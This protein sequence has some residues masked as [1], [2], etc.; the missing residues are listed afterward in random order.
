MLAAV[1]GCGGSALDTTQRGGA[2]SGQLAGS[3]IVPPPSPLDTEG[4]AGQRWLGRGGL[5]TCGHAW[6]IE[7]TVGDGRASGEFWRGGIK[8]DISG[9][10]D[11]A[12]NISGIQGR[13]SRFYRN[14]IGPRLM[15]FNVV[16]GPREA[17]GE[18]YFSDGRCL[19]PMRLVPAGN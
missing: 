3:V 19:T 4:S 1:A 5:G 9:P 2:Q 18:H 7:L 13:K 11:S 12:G 14:H 8:Y 17:R 10:L 15:E 6:R 16:F